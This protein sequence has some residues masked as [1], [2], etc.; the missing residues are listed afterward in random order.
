MLG[1]YFLAAGYVPTRIIKC[2]C[3]THGVLFG[4]VVSFYNQVRIYRPDNVTKLLKESL[5]DYVQASVGI[6]NKGKLLV[7]KLL[8]CFAKGMVEDSSLPDW[9]CQFLSQE[10]A[11]MVRNCSSNQKWR[12]PGARSFSIVPFDSRFRYLFLME[13]GDCNS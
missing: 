8:H 9:I 2:V 10:H 1:N 4:G 11:A 12:L 13:D 5:R 6:S 7:P 3:F